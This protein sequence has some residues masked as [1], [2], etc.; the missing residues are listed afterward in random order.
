MGYV[1]ERFDG[2]S[3]LTLVEWGGVGCAMPKKTV[4]LVWSLANLSGDVDDLVSPRLHFIKIMKE[5]ECGPNIKL[6]STTNIKYRL[7]L[8]V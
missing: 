3:T 1:V 4:I 2:R 8:F 5:K 7:K 6:K